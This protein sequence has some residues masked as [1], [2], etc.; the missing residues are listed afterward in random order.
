MA[1]GA[2]LVGAPLFLQR[3]YGSLRQYVRSIIETEFP[4]LDVSKIRSEDLEF[5]QVI[6][7]MYVVHGFFEDG[8]R[9]AKEAV[10][11]F[12][13]LKV[14]EF[15]IGRTEFAKDSQAVL[16]GRRLAEDLLQTIR[17]DGLRKLVASATSA[18]ALVRVLIE[19]LDHV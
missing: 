15:S 18:G 1:E 4:H 3:R 10:R 7:F 16:L 19:N 9:A 14:K 11:V 12:G 17:D 8:H 13:R 5:V 6:T 2:L